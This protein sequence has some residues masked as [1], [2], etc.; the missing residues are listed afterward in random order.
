MKLTCIVHITC[1]F[2]T[3]PLS[4]QIRVT[5]NC[6]QW[7][8]HPLVK[9]I[10]VYQTPLVTKEWI[11]R[12][13]SKL[14]NL[15]VRSMRYEM[16][17]GKD[18]LY[19]Q[20][21]VRGTASKPTYSFT[22][23]DYF[24]SAAKKYAPVLV[25]SHGYTP[26]ILQS[27]P[28]EWGGFMDTP[29]N[30]STW[31]DINKN[32]ATH[33]KQKSYTNSYVEIWNEPDLT[34]GFFTGTLEDYL[35][36]YEYAAPA[37]HEGYND[38]KVGGPAGAFNGW[39]QPLVE[40]AKA[41]NLP[42]DFLSGHAYGAD[43]SWQLNAMRTALTSLGNNE[44]EMLL[45]EYA[46]YV[47]AD[48]Q[49]NGPVEKA[50]AAM[51]FFNALPGMLECPD[52]TYVNWAQYIDPGFF[53]GDKLG[54]IDRDSGARKALYYAFQL[55]G[56]MPADRRQITIGGN[57]LKGMASAS[58]DCVAAVVWNPDNSEKSLSL[59]LTNIPFESGK[60]EV[61]HIDETHN[62]WYETHRTN[63]VAS[64]NEKVIITDK[65]FSL[66][67][68]V[69]GKGVFFVRLTADQATTLFP[70]INLGTIVR[71]RQWF[72]RRTNDAAYAIFDPKTW[73]VRLSSN[74]EEAGR[75]L[76]GVEVEKMPNYLQVKG[77]RNG[78]VKRSNSK[79]A[80]AIRVDYQDKEGAYTKSVL[81][82]S[83][84][85]HSARTARLPWGTQR[86]AD[87]KVKV[88]NLN[89][90]TIDLTTH[91]PASFSGRVMLTCDMEA[92]GTGVKQNFQFTRGNAET[93]GI[94][95]MNQDESTK[96]NSIYEVYD[97]QGR[98]V[99]SSSILHPA[100][101]TIHSPRL[102]QGIYVVRNSDHSTK[103]ILIK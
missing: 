14:N 1:L 22:D 66:D 38:M 31:A 82:Y 9:K 68:V 25:I 8:E 65:R 91:R 50:E 71:T 42:L 3:I 47:P 28:D 35:K 97:L 27:R 53:V 18:D 67:D 34:D 57:I 36:I 75:A 98:C 49:A 70:T 69:R 96:Q 30:F 77:K 2:M 33:W 102:P 103:K 84:T 5:V 13:V 54:L 26:T 79:A 4:A 56:M 60:L 95:E 39:H 58:D 86:E 90:F 24:L 81:Y 21:C 92:V 94:Q 100:R 45:T 12:D 16:A 85:Y 37:V 87:E 78:T 32:F 93:I 41:K 46:P 74:K 17:C 10:G 64:R 99:S 15:E 48:Y 6:T 29:T 23:I 52:L 101:S 59:T 19:G 73:T 55:Y 20:P 43:Y 61:Y 76:V 80:I 11:S 83:D 63:F 88:A 72:P 40:Y 7:I 62:S 89:D 44:A 51:T